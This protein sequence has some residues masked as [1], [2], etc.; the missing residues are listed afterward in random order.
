[1]NFQQYQEQAITT[2]I[3]SPEVAIPYVVLGI[4]GEAGEIAEKV[5]KA[6]RDNNGV[7]DEDRKRELS[8]EVGDVLWYLAALC[9]ELGISLNDVAE[10]NIQKLQSRKDRGVLKGSG[11][12]R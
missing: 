6:L 5:K 7:I 10:E 11:D 8:K 12:N 1:M 9:E 2:K 4:T 3:Y